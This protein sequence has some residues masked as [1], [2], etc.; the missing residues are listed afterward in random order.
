M[1]LAIGMQLLDS[2]CSTFKSTRLGTKDLSQVLIYKMI[3]ITLVHN[4]NDARLLNPT[5][6]K[7]ELG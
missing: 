1:A 5:R 7:A 3:I 6:G 4:R 2:N